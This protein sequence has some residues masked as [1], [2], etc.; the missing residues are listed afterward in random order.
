[1][2]LEQRVR[3]HNEGNGAQYTTAGGRLSL[4]MQLSSPTFNRLM[5]RKSKSKDGAGRNVRP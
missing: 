2:D 5:R 3:D 4:S 1:M